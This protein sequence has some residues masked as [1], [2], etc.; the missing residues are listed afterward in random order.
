MDIVHVR[1]RNLRSRH[2]DRLLRLGLV[3][4]LERVP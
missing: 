1:G 2:L 4:F 3:E